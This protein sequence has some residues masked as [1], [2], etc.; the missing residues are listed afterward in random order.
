[1]K[2]M[3]RRRLFFA[4]KEPE[5]GRTPGDCD[6]Q[7]ENTPLLSLREENTPA[8]SGWGIAFLFARIAAAG[9]IRIRRK[10]QSEALK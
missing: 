8:S 4:G 5:D 9:V 2:P 10:D 6:I 3:R 1:M 7:K